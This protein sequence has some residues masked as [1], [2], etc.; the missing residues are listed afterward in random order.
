MHIFTNHLEG[1]F[2]SRPNRFI[3]MVEIPSGEIVKC[4]CPNPGR[5]W[6]LLLPR[7][8]VILQKNN[9]GGSTT[10]TLVAVYSRGL[11]VPLYA[12][13]SNA[14][15][16]SLIIPKLFPQ[17]I[18]VEREVTWGK[19]RFDFRV[20]TKTKTIYI[21]V[22]SCSLIEYNTAM[23]PDAPSERATK[24]LKE[25]VE[26]S[27]EPNTEGHVI[28]VLQSPRAEQFIPN[29]HTDPLFAQ[30]MWESQTYLNYHGV[31]IQTEAT[32]KVTYNSD[33]PINLDPIDQ[34]LRKKKD[35]GV[36]MILMEIPEQTTVSIGKLGDI[37]FDKGYYIYTGSAKAGLSK[38]VKRHLAK[39]KKKHWHM[40][41]LTQKAT[42]KKGIP[43]FTNKE[44]ECSMATMVSNIGGRGVPLFGCSD[45]DCES[46][47]FYFPENPLHSREFLD[48]LFFLRH[49]G[50][51]EE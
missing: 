12:A 22:K 50:F 32:G 10:H 13:K 24:H 3:V 1:I 18:K 4:H 31:S 46:H 9:P 21:E 49:K 41:Y 23:F 48:L 25:L 40:D 19:S 5:L 45:C 35:S 44:L 6:E 8:K 39:R 38:R 27:K 20:T 16:E 43:I 37:P 36:Y 51:Y 34:L 33:V 29:I 42:W 15:T 28:F 26:L 17:A 30:T 11:I 7:T 47:L 14:M 2:I